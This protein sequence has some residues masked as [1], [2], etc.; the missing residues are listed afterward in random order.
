[1]SALLELRDAHVR[2][3]DGTAALQGVDLSLHAQQW[4]GLVGESGSGKSTAVRALLR[5]LKVDRGSVHW[6]GD[7]VTAVPERALR[8]RRRLVQPVL[9]D[10]RSSL[11]G[12][13]SVRALLAEPLD[14]HRLHAGAARE[15]RLVD[16]LTR[17]GLEGSFLPRHPHQLSGGQRQRVALARALA[18]EPRA[19]LLDEPVS[20]LDVSVAAQVLN[21]LVDI[22]RAGG[23]GCL[24]V[25]HDMSLV[26]WLCPRVTVLYRG[27][28][29]ESGAADAVTAA[30]A[31]PYT[32][33][34]VDAAAGRAPSPLPVAAS[35]VAPACTFAPRCPRATDLCRTDPPALRVVDNAG[36]LAACH[37]PR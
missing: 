34:L 35:M 6:D 33:L 19:L 7:D 16:L 30:P 9:Q 12:R 22:A 5:L 14:I 26:R 8:A 27:R 24:L 31:H 1:M 2:Y 25:T 17:V 4:H 11:N 13:M 37:H 10:P 28:V 18:V 21:L 29:V 32:G 3:A 23:L 36:R 20:A 15:A